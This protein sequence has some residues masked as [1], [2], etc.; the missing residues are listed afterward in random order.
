[1]KINNKQAIKFAIIDVLSNQWAFEAPTYGECLRNVP[2]V[3]G[4]GREYVIVAVLR[5]E[6][7]QP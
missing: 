3:I 5:E 6:R 2:K 1:M 7:R 4:A